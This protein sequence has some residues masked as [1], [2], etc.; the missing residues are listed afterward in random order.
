MLH[1][2]SSIFTAEANALLQAL[3]WIKVSLLKKFII[4][5]D[6]HPCLEAICALYPK[7]AIIRAIRETYTEIKRQGKEVVLCWVPSHIGIDGNEAAD[8]A[9]KKALRWPVG[10]DQIPYTDVLPMTKTHVMK[11]WQSTW[12]GHRHPLPDVKS[13]K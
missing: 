11:S 13:S 5:S 9:A 3:K 4:F 7:D 6:S 2:Q 12:N 10:A 8:T 1:K